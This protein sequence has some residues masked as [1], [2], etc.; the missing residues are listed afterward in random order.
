MRKQDYLVGLI[1]AL[2]PNEKRYFKIFSGLQPGGKRYLKL[3]DALENKKT[4]DGTELCSE[5]VLEPWQL[6][7]DKHYLTQTLLQ[8]LRNYEQDSTELNILRNS[9]ENAQGLINRRMFSF[10]NDILEKG[11]AR[12]WELEAFELIGPMLIMRS[13]CLLN[14]GAP[15]DDKMLGKYESAAASLHEIIEQMDLRSQAR[16]LEIKAAEGAHFEKILA[17]PLIKGNINKLKSLRA[18]SLRYETLAHYHSMVI[19]MPALLVLARQER[20]LYLKHP[21]IKIINPI[22]YLTNLARLANGENNFEVSLQLVRDLQKELSDPEIKIS[23]QRRDSIM[24]TANMLII[25][26]LRH[27]HRFKESLSLAEKLYGQK[28]HMSDYQKLSIGFE[29]ALLL[30]HNRKAALAAEKTDELLRIKSDVRSDMQPFIRLLHVMAQMALGNYAIMA[31]LI[32]SAR[33]WMKKK[34][35]GHAEVNLFLKHMVLIAKAPADKQGA[36]GALLKDIEAG[37]METITRLL[38]FDEWVKDMIKKGL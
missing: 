37:K 20:Q 5:L 10:A 16:N 17:H 26:N 13:S 2:E 33:F 7:D 22:V 30:L 23:N 14:T 6:A 3:F 32:K 25:W 15:S 1:A 35:S 4:Y 28:H 31:H 11:L 29:Y 24:W 27:L 12:A 9:K 38:Q 21:G 36:W 19:N 18:K 34:D 8:S